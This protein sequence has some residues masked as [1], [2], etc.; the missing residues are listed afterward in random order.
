MLAIFPR[1]EKLDRVHHSHTGIERELT[2]SRKSSG[3]T[4]MSMVVWHIRF[5]AMP[6]FHHV[7]PIIG[8]E[9]LPGPDGVGG[10]Q[11]LLTSF[12]RY[13]CL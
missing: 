7:G 2:V 8:W 13:Q 12:T 3:A 9:V 4:G 1:E 10:E 5:V 6:E 11:S